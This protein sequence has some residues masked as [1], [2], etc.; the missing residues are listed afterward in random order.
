MTLKL[1]SIFG[2]LFGILGALSVTSAF[3]MLV[4]Y[5]LLIIGSSLWVVYGIIVKNHPLIYMNFVFTII[6]LIGI[7][8]YS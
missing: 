1:L 8:N 6:N 5:V 2:A 7:I 4:G 3:A